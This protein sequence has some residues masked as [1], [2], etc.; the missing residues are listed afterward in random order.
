MGTPPA[1]TAAAQNLVRVR[2]CDPETSFLYIKVT[3]FQRPSGLGFGANMPLT[4]GLLPQAQ[5]DA[6]AGW[7]NRGAPRFEAGDSGAS[8][9]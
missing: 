3:L 1:I 2:P 6:I 9:P 8:C 7:I 5:L 4:G